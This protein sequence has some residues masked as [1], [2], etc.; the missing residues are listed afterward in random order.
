MKNYLATIFNHA[1]VKQALDTPLN[2]ASCEISD[3]KKLGS[4]SSCC[5][6]HTQPTLRLRR[7]QA[8]AGANGAKALLSN[9]LEVVAFQNGAVY[10][11]TCCGIRCLAQVPCMVCQC[12][13]CGKCERAF[14]D[15]SH[16]FNSQPCACDTISISVVLNPLPDLA[17]W[18]PCADTVASLVIGSGI[19]ATGMIALLVTGSLIPWPQSTSQSRLLLHCFAL[20]M[21]RA[22]GCL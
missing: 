12:M 10:N 1:F 4:V 16:F 22:L 20:F 2:F 17:K 13:V 15:F 5:F 11:C 6:Y 19:Q 8:K 18:C 3:L 21:R 9:N 14:A 7:L